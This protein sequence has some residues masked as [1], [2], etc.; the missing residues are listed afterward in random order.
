[1]GNRAPA[2]PTRALTTAKVSQTYSITSK[3]ISIPD[4]KI[5]FSVFMDKERCVKYMLIIVPCIA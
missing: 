2:S 5:R 1:M 3:Y 4:A